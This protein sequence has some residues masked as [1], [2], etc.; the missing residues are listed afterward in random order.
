VDII[1][2]VLR[3]IIADSPEV[4]GWPLS[5]GTCWTERFVVAKQLLIEGLFVEA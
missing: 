4:L 2:Q 5:L 3:D 1:Y